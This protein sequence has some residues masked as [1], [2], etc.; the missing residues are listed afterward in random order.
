MDLIKPDDP[1]YDDARTIFNSMIDKRP[2]VI[3]QCG[4]AA[5][6][7][8]ALQLARDNSYEVAVRA[9]G[10]SVA[11]MCLNDGGIVI[12]V[13]RMTDIEVD[14]DARQVRVRRRGHVGRVRPRHAGARVGHHR[15]PGVDHRRRGAH[16][17]RWV[18]LARA[19]VRAG[20]RQPRR[21]RPGDRRRAR[22]HRER[23]RE[24]RAVLGVARWWGQLR[25]GDVVRVPPLPR[26]PDAHRRSHALARRRRPRGRGASIATSRT[27]RPTSSA[28][29]R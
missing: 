3:A 5:D 19:Q 27:T 17:G 7:I 12:D 22:G 8:S 15:R 21:R 2:A 4:S 11:G 18:R 9:G 16:P 20:V 13:R 26:R 25:G 6:V 1:Q 24:P 28:P 29:R 23:D 10:H 14:A